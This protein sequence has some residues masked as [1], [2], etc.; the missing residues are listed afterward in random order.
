MGFLRWN[1]LNWTFKM[2]CTVAT[3]SMV[4]FWVF[5][6]QKNDDLSVIE[7][8]HISNIKEMINPEFNVCFKRPFLSDKLGEINTDISFD[9][10]SEYIEGKLNFDDRHKHID[11]NNVTLELFEHL[12]DYQIQWLGVNSLL[13]CTSVQKCSFV[14]LKTSFEGSIYNEFHKCFGVEIKNPKE[15][16]LKAIY[17]NFKPT[18]LGDLSQIQKANGYSEIAFV[19]IHYPNQFLKPENAR[20][21]WKSSNESSATMFMIT[22][23]EVLKRR[24][25]NKEPCLSDWKTYDD[26]LLNKHLERVTCRT[27]YQNTPK[28]ICATK[29]EMLKSIYEFSVDRRANYPEPCQ[30]ISKIDYQHTVTTY[31]NEEKILQLVV[32]IPQKIRL[33][34]QSQS[35]DVQALIGNIGGYIGLFLGKNNKRG[36]LLIEN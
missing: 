12:K 32:V 8:K 7:Y 3:I 21:I 22:T 16:I 35:V 20:F 19:T 29:R 25:K 18:L 17:I 27:P 1:F 5:K 13:N 9:H 33:I 31:S 34:T 4:S 24:N 23:M 11:F 10:H 14:T 15:K 2:A 26:L 30:E 36:T 6:F 28:P